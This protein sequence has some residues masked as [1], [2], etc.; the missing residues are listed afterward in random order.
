MTFVEFKFEYNILYYAK[1][2]SV[3]PSG[4]K[5]KKRTQ[6]HLYVQFIYTMNAL[7]L[8]KPIMIRLFQSEK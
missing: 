4:P 7:V 8:H 5:L 2:T 6:W 3:S 1:S